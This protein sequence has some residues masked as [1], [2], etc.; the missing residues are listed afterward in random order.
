MIKKPHP[1]IFVWQIS[2]ILSTILIFLHLHTT[3]I[4]GLLKNLNVAYD[5]THL[6]RILINNSMYAKNMLYDTE[7]LLISMN[8]SESITSM[9]DHTIAF[10]ERRRVPGRAT[11]LRLPTSSTPQRHQ[12]TLEWS[13]P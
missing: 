9:A 8:K 6:R 12:K 4:F 2:Q 13:Q 11:S 7:K 10:Y 3:I 1:K 5:Y